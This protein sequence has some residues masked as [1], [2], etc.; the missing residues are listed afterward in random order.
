[1]WKL[2]VVPVCS[3][4]WTAAAKTIARISSSLSQCCTQTDTY[5]NDITLLA[6]EGNISHISSQFTVHST[7]AE[8]ELPQEGPFWCATL[9]FSLAPSGPPYENV[10][11]APLLKGQNCNSIVGHGLKANPCCTVLLRHKML[12]ESQVFFMTVCK[13]RSVCHAQ[14]MKHN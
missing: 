6:G 8:S 3:K 1:M 13:C 2:L 14:I 4:S 10:L 7:G 12:P 5:K 9:R 11:G